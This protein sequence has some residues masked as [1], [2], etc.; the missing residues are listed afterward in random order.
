MYL[1]NA[2]DISILN[3]VNEAVWGIAG[4][5][6]GLLLGALG[7]W[8][9]LRPRLSEGE[10]HKAQS[11]GLRTELDAATRRA[12]EA[13]R[14]VARLEVQAGQAEEL[15]KERDAARAETAARD[16]VVQAKEVEMAGLRADIAAREKALEEERGLLAE[17]ESK[18]KDAFAGLATQSLE[19]ASKQLLGLA[20]EHFEAQHEVS[21]GDLNQ[22]KQEIEAL[23]QPI[24]LRLNDLSEQTQQMGK[25]RAESFGELMEQLRSLGDQQSSLRGETKRLITALQD[26]GK[27]GSWGEMI[28]ER[29]VEMAG[30]EERITYT[31][32][33][34]MRS[35][36]GLAQRP[37]MI[38]SL[39]GGRCIII[40]AKTPMPDYLKG[41]EEEDQP[42]KEALFR[43]HAKKMLD[44][45]KELRKRDYSKLPSAP[46]FTVM[47]VPS[48]GAFRAAVSARPALIEEAMDMNV[49]IATPTTLLALLRAVGYGWRQERLAQNAEKIQKEAQSVYEALSVMVGHYA[50]LGK[51]ITDCGSHFNAL[52]ASLESR[53]LPAARRFKDHG[54]QTAREIEALNPV[55]VSPRQ[56]TAK[57]LQPGEALPGLD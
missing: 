36:E 41:T 49:A 2:V 20:K 29:V 14:Q 28:L 52:G 33:T 48:E 57:E 27:S 12:T 24:R 18:F 10:G 46:D 51:A 6:I 25:E 32:Q 37:D 15:R 40:D 31:T 42:M 4:M 5:V 35:D 11:E 56:L 9:A 23:L 38:V 55:E 34:T 22:K 7:I 43:D 8:V 21:K 47:F 17:A 44:H 16:L 13:E 19:A 45:A 1:A 26:P 39:P 3:R 54:L 53:V 30:L 50:K